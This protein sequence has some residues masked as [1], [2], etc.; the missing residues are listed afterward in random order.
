MV[1]Y[2]WLADAVV[3][4]HATWV[5]VV[6]GGLLVVPVGAYFRWRWVRNFWFRAIHLAMITIVAVESLLGIECPY[7]TSENIN[8]LLA[9]E[10]PGEGTFCYCAFG[11]LVVIA[12]VFVPPEW[13][14][15]GRLA[16]RNHPDR[17][18]G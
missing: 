3:V 15:K 9:G 12:L 7:T 14:W 1:I 4:M 11:A 10:R 17:A 2:R 13:P 6:M 5:A 8:R 16:R 18:S